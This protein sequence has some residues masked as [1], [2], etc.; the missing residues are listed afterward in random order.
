MS[1]DQP[2]EPQSSE[3][4]SNAA[5]NVMT[6]QP[7]LVPRSG[8][9]PFP[10]FDPLVNPANTGLRWRKW[11][12]RFQNLLTSLGETDPVVK[13]GLLLTYVEETTNDIFDS[14]ANTGTD[15]QS[16]VTKLTERFDPATNKDMEI[17]EFRQITQVAGESL[18][19]F[20]RRLKE[21]SSTCQFD[22]EDAE[23]RTQII[24]K[25]I[26]T[27][28]RRKALRKEMNLE[29]MLKYGLALEK[30]DHQ[31]KVLEEENNTSRQTNFVRSRR[32]QEQHYKRCNSQGEN[33][34]NNTP[35][36]STKGMQKCRNCG[37]PYPHI[38]GKLSC[39]AAGKKCFQCGKIGH[40]GKYCLSKLRQPTQ[41]SRRTEQSTYQC[42]RPEQQTHQHHPRKDVCGLSK[43]EPSNNFSDTGEE[44]IYVITTPNKAPEITV[45]IAEVPTNVIIDTGSSVNILNHEHFKKIK[46]KNPSIQLQP[47]KIKVF[48]Y[49]AKQALSLL[50][51]ITAEVRTN[52]ATTTDV[53]LVTNDN[54]TCLLSYNTSA[55]LGL[56]SINMNSI[57]IH[58]SDQRVVQVLE[59]P[60]KVFEGTG[61][62]KNCEVKLEIDSNVSPVAQASRRIPH[63][64]RKKV[65]EKIHEMEEQGIIE[66]VQGVTPWLTPL[67]P[68]PEKNGDL[69]IVLD[70]RVPNQA[71]KRRRIQ[72]PTVDEILHKMEGATIFTEVDLSQGYLQI[73]LAEE[74]RYITAFQTPDDG[75]YQ[76]RRLIM[77]AC[78]SGEYFHEIIHNLI[79]H[80]PNCQNI[81]DNIWLWSKDMTEHIKQL[82]QLL[83][84]IK[85][86]GLT[87]KFPKCSFATSEINVFGHIVS[88]Q[89]IQPDKKKIEA[90]ANATP[91]KTSAEVRSFLGL[92]NYC[93]RY[94]H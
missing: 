83:E 86:S 28:L 1:V 54:N 5:S 71:L 61:N 16:A 36:K 68:I 82:D 73:T 88:S 3:I 58:H 66:K 20:Y 15:Y 29:A 6:A 10:P 77:G 23:I 76:F 85:R 72:F 41:S 92:V 70:M 81:S 40:F 34:R 17:Y 4:T 7:L 55:T 50:R 52:L 62:L 47:T 24:H 46:K 89:G 22:N 78:P 12:R 25:T 53:F 31:S 79:K 35:L 59:A 13:R 45:K 64:M 8:L 56:L 65:N 21:K 27:R 90:V 37:G 91:P 33:N 32:G 44:F 69:R 49:G 26:D 84:T 43:Q 38:G 48:A 74:S 57:F 80:I 9:P 19:E 2:S 67:I 60:R 75:P 51:Q 42:H 11:L 87:L 30:S 14:L 18:N 39:P 93:S 63:S 94:I